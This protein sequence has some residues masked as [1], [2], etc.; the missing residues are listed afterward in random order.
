ML[1]ENTG[2]Y[3]YFFFI[4]DFLSINYDASSITET[5]ILI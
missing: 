5:T 3:D 1:E 2:M 4:L